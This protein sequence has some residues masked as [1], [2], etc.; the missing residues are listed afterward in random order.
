MKFIQCKSAFYQTYDSFSVNLFF[1]CIFSR[2]RHFY[3]FNIPLGANEP[4]ICGVQTTLQGY[5]KD[6]ISRRYFCCGSY[7][8][9]LL[10]YMSVLLFFCC[11]SGVLVGAA[12]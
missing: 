12:E 2:K 6:L 3:C 5:G 8:C 7:C 10:L 4:A 9:L 1:G 11:V